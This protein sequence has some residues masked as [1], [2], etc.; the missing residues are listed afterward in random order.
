M[1]T[2]ACLEMPSYLLSKLYLM[3]LTWPGLEA[4]IFHFFRRIDRRR[5]GATRAEIARALSKLRSP[6][7]FPVVHSVIWRARFLCA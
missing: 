1:L 3:F 5:K 2:D 6:I 4:E 7:L